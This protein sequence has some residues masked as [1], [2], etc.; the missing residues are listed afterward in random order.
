ML[1]GKTIYAP[2]KMTIILGQSYSLHVVL[3]LMMYINKVIV[4]IMLVILKENIQILKTNSR[5]YARLEGLFK[6]CCYWVYLSAL[7]PV[8]YYT[9]I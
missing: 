8:T 2:T 3:T 9:Y 7:G 6:P 5:V 1:N 4:I